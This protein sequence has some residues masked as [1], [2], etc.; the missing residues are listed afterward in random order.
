MVCPQ[1]RIYDFFNIVARKHGLLEYTKNP[2]G[3]IF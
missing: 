3:R 2:P 1:S